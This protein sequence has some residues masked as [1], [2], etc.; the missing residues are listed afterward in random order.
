MDKVNFLNR[1]NFPLYAEG[2][3]IVQNAAF[4]AA[5]CALIGGDN[6]ILSGC[7]ENS[8]HTS[9]SDGYI[10]INGEILPFSGGTIKDKIK[11]VETKQSLHAFGVDYPESYIFKVAQFSETGDINWSDIER[12]R[13]NQN[14]YKQIKDI[15]GD[16]AGTIKM[17]AGM[18]AKIPKD[19]MLCDGSEL[20]INSYPEL[21][22]NLGV[23]FGGDGQSS[24]R[25]PDLKGRFVVG[26]DNNDIDYNNIGKTG[27]A[28]KKPISNDNMPVHS[29][30]Y[31]DDTNAMGSFILDGKS[32]PS[33]VEGINNQE[34]SAKSG[35]S[36]TLYRT[37]E[38][39]KGEE[40]DVRPP[41][42]TLAYII[43]VR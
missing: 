17:W 20:A 8:E 23:S 5:M 6:Y 14:L 9:V 15:T 10:V 37:S 4:M 24:F 18:I 27:G 3:N 12:L 30:I 41:F 26:Y 13:T 39:G 29:H 19:Y 34:S 7:V 33:K 16:A 28:K 21:Y 11:I 2:V 35:G 31:S 1:D 25:I 38:A 36:G 42:F 40:F 43:K 32:F 22:D